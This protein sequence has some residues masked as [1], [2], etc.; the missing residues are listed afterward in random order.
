MRVSRVHSFRF[1]SFSYT[2]SRLWSPRIERNTLDNPGQPFLS[3]SSFNVA[4]QKTS[5]TCF[6]A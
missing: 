2:S 5:N 6:E 4:L 1:A 3:K